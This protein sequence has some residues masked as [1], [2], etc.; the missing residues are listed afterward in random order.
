M[1]KIHYISYDNQEGV[2]NKV[3]LKK[4]SQAITSQAEKL[5]TSNTSIF[6][7]ATIWRGQFG[8]RQFGGGNLSA[9]QF[10]GEPIWRRDNLAEK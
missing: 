8:G 5:Q 9:S 1:S 6:G 3:A 4:I 2:D 10:G 7:Y